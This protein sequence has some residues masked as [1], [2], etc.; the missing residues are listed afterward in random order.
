MEYKLFTEPRFHDA[1]FYKD[2]ELANHWEQPGH[3]ERLRMT[4]VRCAE[5]LL[6]HP[7]IQT[8]SDW[9]CGNGRLLEELQRMFPQRR[10][11][12]C[13][14][15]PANVEDAKLRGYP[16]HYHDFVNDPTV[17]G[18]LAILTEVLEHLIDPHGLLK[19]LASYPDCHWIVASSPANE[20]KEEHYE[21]HS[22]V[23]TEWSYE[24]MF[25]E[26]G[27]PFVHST[28]FAGARIVVAHR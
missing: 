18:N 9:G 21:F 11:Y 1:Q 15:L 26:N 3:G 17:T 2:I 7:D 10:Y 13:D 22:W 23:W 14:L 24:T 16:V 27:W 6:E 25:S 19:R 28:N 20:T 12:G 8:V 4:F 5:L